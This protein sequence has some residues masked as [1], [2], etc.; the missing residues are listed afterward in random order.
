[1]IT[2][3][4]IIAARDSANDDVIACSNCFHQ[5]GLKDEYCWHCG[6]QFSHKKEYPFFD[7]A[8]ELEELLR[9][10]KEAENVRTNTK[11]RANYW[12]SKWHRIR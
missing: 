12:F 8:Y 11:N 5:T 1:M 2:A 9:L 6:A 3:K 4:I 10:N 7:Y